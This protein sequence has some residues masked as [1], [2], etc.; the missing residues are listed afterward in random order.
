MLANR[1]DIAASVGPSIKFL[2]FT[3]PRW[4]CAVCPLEFDIPEPWEVGPWGEMSPEL[5]EARDHFIRDH[6][7]EYDRFH[8]LG[9]RSEFA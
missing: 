5:R 8:I 7:T 2:V 9:E 4:K 1:I 3:S 6:G